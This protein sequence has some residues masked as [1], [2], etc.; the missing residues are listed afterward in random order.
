MAAG[1]LALGAAGGWVAT[2]LSLPLP[3]M[4]GAMLVTTPLAALGGPLFVHPKLRTAMVTIL[5]VMLGSQFSPA[6]LDQLDRWAAGLGVLVLYVVVSGALAVV[7][8]RRVCRYDP[9]TAYFSAMPGGLSE[10]IIVGSAMGGDARIISLSHAA[11]V[12]LVVMTLPFAFQFAL[13]YDT[14]DRP[15]AGVPIAEL[16][17]TELAILLAC[18][19]LGY[20]LARLMR[21]PAAQVV[22]PMVV[23]AAVHFAGLS[24]ASPP[25]ELVAASQVVIG[26]AIGSR[27]AGV[28]LR[29]IL[30]AVAGAAGVTAVLLAMTV[31]FALALAAATEAPLSSLILAYAPGG[32]AEMS[33]VALA[34]SV[35]TA[36]V[37][38]H[39]IVRIFLVVVLAP[40]AFRLFRRAESTGA[41]PPES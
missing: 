17:T 38:T 10:M 4:I 37:A 21:V 41:P 30:K 32:L 35:D 8:L 11:R 25:I 6:I 27:F 28:D 26:A 19:V 9:I 29:F 20:A 18:A 12:L 36:F 1:T 3:W 33:L 5:G 34:L 13:D 7:F 24:Q 31:V 40:A 15:A 23:S 22:G 14:G 16:P 39:H 2:W